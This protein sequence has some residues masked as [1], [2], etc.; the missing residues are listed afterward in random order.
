MDKGWAKWPP[1][2][3]EHLILNWLQDLTTCFTAWTTECGERVA[4]RRQFYRGSGSYLEGFPVKRKM[5]VGITARH[6]QSKIDEDGVGE[7]S[8][9]LISRWSEILVIE[10]LKSNPTEDGQTPVWLDLATYA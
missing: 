8:D 2:A 7:T 6:G 9:T 4:A 1:N 3:R 5:D 10:E